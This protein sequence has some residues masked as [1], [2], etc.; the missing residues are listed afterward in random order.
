MVWPVLDSGTHSGVENMSVDRLALERVTETSQPLLRFF[1]WDKPA[2]SYGYLLDDAKVKQWTD[3]RI[4]NRESKIDL[5][6]RPTGGGA[7]MHQ[8]S[9]LSF[10][11]L[12]PRR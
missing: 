3:A 12:W 8:P 7:V 5:V 4:E 1:Q 9:D 11:L 2:V 6:R 10:S